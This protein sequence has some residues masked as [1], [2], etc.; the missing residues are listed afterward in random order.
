M[1]RIY[2][3][4]ERWPDAPNDCT[5]AAHATL[6]LA[7]VLLRKDKRHI[8]WARKKLAGI[9]RMGYI[10]PY[11]FRRKMAELWGLTNDQVGEVESVESWW[12]PNNE[13]NIPILTEMR[14]VVNE[15]HEADSQSMD[16]LTS[17]RD[18]KSIFARLDIR[19][20]GAQKSSASLEGISPRSDI[21]GGA[22]SDRGSSTSSFSPTNPTFGDS[23]VG[24][25]GSGASG[26]GNIASMHHE[27]GPRRQPKRMDSGS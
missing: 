27:T 1:C 2:E 9:E 16:S 20:Q 10:Y 24:G 5:L 17:V 6:G 21:S 8:M 22:Q 18:V 13:G 7:L 11:T 14:R 3:A 25:G 26:G 19:S 4:I 23:R 15:R 12:L